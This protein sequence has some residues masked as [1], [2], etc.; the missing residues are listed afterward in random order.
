MAALIARTVGWDSQ[1]W[2][3]RFPDRGT[4][5]TDLWRNVGTLEHYGVARGYQDG[6]YQPTGVVLYAQTI[7]FITRAMV[8]IGYWQQ[9]SDDPAIY[10]NVPASSGHR[11]DIATYVGYAGPVPGF[12]ASPQAWS[13]WDQSSWTNERVGLDVLRLLERRVA[14]LPDVALDRQLA[15]FAKVGFTGELEASR[16][17]GVQLITV[18]DLLL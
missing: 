11:A 5:D 6:S 12:P 7:S 4:V 2:G 9:L 13:G 8:A 17:P 14:L 1:D 18:D 16:G 3:N 10:P 15:L